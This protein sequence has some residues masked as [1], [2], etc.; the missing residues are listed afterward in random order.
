MEEVTTDM[1]YIN[2]SKELQLIVI[3][4]DG[5]KNVCR[6]ENRLHDVE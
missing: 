2:F 5:F 6:P 1:P 3:L 4:Q